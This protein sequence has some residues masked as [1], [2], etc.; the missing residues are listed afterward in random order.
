MAAPN[1]ITLKMP[2][3]S[4]PFADPTGNVARQWYYLLIGLWNRT[5][6]APGASTAD[7]LAAAE[8]AQ[9]TAT[10][11]VGDAAAAQS[12]AN[13]ALADAEAAQTTANGAQT[14]ANTANTAVAAETA[15]AETAE[16]LLAPLAS[17][18]GTGTATWPGFALAAGPTWTGGSGVPASTQPK[19]SLYSRTGGA[20]G[21]TLYVSQGGGTWNPV[22]GV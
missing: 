22:A 20:V 8:A 21:S 6:G 5:G 4:E 2:L 19:G 11:A 12:T 15:R 9:N 17:P 14:S 7:A 13:T 18:A 10:T 16:A 3:P 1:P